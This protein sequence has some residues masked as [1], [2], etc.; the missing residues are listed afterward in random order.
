[1]CR[2]RVLVMP[3]PPGPGPVLPSGG[4]TR[5]PMRA[6]LRWLLG[7]RTNV[8][9][10]GAADTAG[11]RTVGSL[12][13]RH[14][15]VSEPQAPEE[16]AGM[17]PR[18]VA[19]GRSGRLTPRRVAAPVRPGRTPQALARGAS[20]P[21]SQPGNACSR[22]WPSRILARSSRPAPAGPAMEGMT[23]ARG[24]RGVRPVRRSRTF[25]HPVRR[26]PGGHTRETSIPGPG[27]CR[28]RSVSGGVRCPR[29]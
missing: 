29:P 28:G 22:P 9:G 21:D 20:A 15:A 24:R 26:N 6:A 18:R 7:Q 19:W 23:I 11:D 25:I 4:R 14:A 16:T 2:G 12:E 1:V 3:C 10:P 13:A 17:T 5:R 27:T 8:A